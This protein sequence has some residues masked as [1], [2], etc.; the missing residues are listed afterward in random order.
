HALTV[1]ATDPTGNTSAESPPVNIVVDTTAPT[2]PSI[3]T[4]TDDAGSVTGT[5][6]DGQTTDDTTPTLSGT[7]NAGDV[8]TVYD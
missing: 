8:I 7:G 6:T 1:T 2:A 3:G 4:V 5:L